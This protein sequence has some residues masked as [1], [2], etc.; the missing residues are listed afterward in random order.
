M[1]QSRQGVVVLTQSWDQSIDHRGVAEIGFDHIVDG[2]QVQRFAVDMTQQNGGMVEHVETF[3]D[4]VG[5][6]AVV[7]G[8]DDGSGGQDPSTQVAAQRRGDQPH[9]TSRDRNR[10]VVDDLCGW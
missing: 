4:F 10:S 6:S 3:D 8:D 9:A 7:A 1:D 2:R 5:D